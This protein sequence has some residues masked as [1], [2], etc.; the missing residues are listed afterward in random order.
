M[1]IGK[2]SI[3][4]VKKNGYANIQNTAPDMEDSVIL[5]KK[6]APVSKK[7]P[8]KAKPKAESDKVVKANPTTKV[9]TRTKAQKS[10]K[11]G[12]KLPTYLL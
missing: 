7:Q 2:N 6:T 4:R 10:F 11:I 8:A 1:P 5:E 12:E 9:K 3:S